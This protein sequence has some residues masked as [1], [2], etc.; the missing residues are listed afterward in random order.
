M[1]KMFTMETTMMNNIQ[2]YFINL[3]FSDCEANKC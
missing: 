2:E 1:R 3:M